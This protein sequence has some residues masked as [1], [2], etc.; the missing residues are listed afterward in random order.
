MAESCNKT[1]ALFR[2][3]EMSKG[4][5]L[6]RPFVI[7]IDGRSASG[8]TTF[9]K[10][11]ADLC[12]ASVIHTDDFFRP[13]NSKGELELS[14]FEGNFDLERFKNE[15]VDN[16]A[17]EKTF[18]YGVFDCKNGA[19]TERKIISPCS[20]YIIEG[21][22]CLCST[23]GDYADIKLF[24]DISPEKQKERI[25][26]RNGEK[27]LESFLSVWI[28]AEERYISHYNVKNQCD[29]IITEE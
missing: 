24:F 17:F 1:E 22:Y 10:Q 26:F 2:L 14:E 21:A 11:L 13:R 20:V 16:L 12:G 7:A 25:L 6:E 18:S 15:I 4:R 19:I 28:P 9:A 8:K 3:V 29:F 5:S 23:L 27:A